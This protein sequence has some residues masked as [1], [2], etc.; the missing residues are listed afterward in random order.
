M[1][2]DINNYKILIVGRVAWTKNESTLTGVFKGFP[3]D[4]LAYVCIETLEPNFDCCK[5]HFQISEIAM[6][7]RLIKWNTKTGNKVV[8]NHST[9]NEI[10]KEKEQGVLSYVRGHRSIF[11]LYLREL[12]WLM[13]G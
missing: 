5:Q 13:G 6:L 10:N 12:L 4:R 3:S 7:K 11:L 1:C 9:I 8:E 2:T